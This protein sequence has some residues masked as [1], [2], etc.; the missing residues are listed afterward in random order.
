MR[1][2]SPIPTVQACRP[3]DD[4]RWR[5]AF[6]HAAVA[7]LC[8]TAIAGPLFLG[9]TGAEPRFAIE[10]ALGAGIC[11]WAIAAPRPMWLLVPPVVTSAI[12]LIQTIPLPSPLLEA[13]APLSFTAWRVS[14]A[15][16]SNSGATISMDPGA[17][18]MGIRRLFLALSTVA[19]VSDIA[20]KSDVRFWL[21]AASGLSGLIVAV[22]G[23]SFAS[24]KDDR[25][26]LG[27]YDLSGPI[28]FWRTPVAEPAQT[29]AF[30]YPVTVKA[31][32]AQYVVDDWV[33]GDR[34]GPYI[35][36]N[37]FAGALVLT[38]PAA[39]AIWL[40]ASRGKLPSAPRL[41]VAAL[42]YGAAVYAVA[43]RAQSRAG[44]AALILALLSLTTLLA[45]AK[46]L[47][48]V[49]AGATILIGVVILC[50]SAALYGLMPRVDHLFPAS[51][52]PSV[53]R[54]FQDKRAFASH[55]A[56]RMFRVTP[57]FGTG[58]DTYGNLYPRFAK[59]DQPWYF[60]HNDYAQLLSE[61]GLVGTLLGGAFAFYFIRVF[62]RM[63]RSVPPQNR[64]PQAG[65]WAAVAGIAAHSLFDWNMHV[66]A[67]AFLTCVMLGVCLAGFGRPLPPPVG[68][69]R[70]TWA[71]AAF[72]VAVLATVAMLG[73]DA[74]SLQVVAELRSVMAKARIAAEDPKRPPPPYEQLSDVIVKGSKMLR[75]DR[76]NATLAMLVGQAHLHA[77]TAPQPP[78]A[79]DA[80]LE[81]AERFFRIARRHSA[82]CRGLP[83]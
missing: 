9:G 11:L 54:L 24:S 56:L 65:A 51:L 7:I 16:L 33:I 81:S 47:R 23:V 13:I 70:R 82:I 36:S 76:N 67:N 42:V 59:D 61:M 69:I 25:L 29:A 26:L 4:W 10:C 41:V 5:V 21:L 60:A 38:V 17:T 32:R 48:R 45:P 64:L 19:M 14:L 30:S 31:G 68:S 79:A 63:L 8:V 6:E 27:F 44:T 57:V 77:S 18:A 74:R 43:V 1:Q 34:V 72:V 22:L 2:P 3:S 53:A 39:V 37:H 12:C 75:W 15:G 62:V 80:S 52:Q 55:V 71:R 83:E 28:D 66:P 50:V 40:L 58:I 73:R 49:L 46:W 35:I 78:A 20:R